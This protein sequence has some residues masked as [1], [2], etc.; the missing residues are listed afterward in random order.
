LSF[1]INTHIGHTVVLNLTKI[2]NTPNLEC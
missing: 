2:K 1:Q